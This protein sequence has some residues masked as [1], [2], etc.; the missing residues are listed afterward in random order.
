MTNVFPI[1]LEEAIA[2]QISRALAVERCRIEQK[3]R[4]IGLRDLMDLIAGYL[5]SGRVKATLPTHRAREPEERQAIFWEG[6]RSSSRARVPTWNTCSI[7]ITAC[8]AV[9]NASRARNVRTPLKPTI[10]SAQESMIVVSA[11]SR[12]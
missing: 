9:E 8:R 12:D 2:A 3:P 7:S 4:N 1:G 10:N 6:R 5:K 11:A